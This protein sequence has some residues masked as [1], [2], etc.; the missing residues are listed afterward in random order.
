MA[1]SNVVGF[2]S[3]VSIMLVCRR[4]ESLKKA[5]QKRFEEAYKFEKPKVLG[6]ARF[7]TDEDCKRG[8]L[9]TG[10]GLRL[11]YTQSGRLLTY[12]GVSHLLAL[13]ATGLGKG[14]DLLLGAI[15]SL[16]K[17]TL[18]ANDPKGQLLVVSQKARMLV[19]PVLSLNPYGLHKEVTKGVHHVRYNPMAQLRADDPMLGIRCDKIADG[20]IWGGDERSRFWDDA[21]KELLAGI[22]MALVCHGEE[23]DRNLPTLCRVLCGDVYGYCRDV[24]A[25]T[26]NRY[27][28]DRIGPYAADGAADV[29]TIQDTVSTARVNT[30]F[31]RNEVLG[32]SLSASDFSFKS[33]RE[34]P[35]SL[36]LVLPVNS[37]D[38]CDRYYRLIFA[39]ALSEM[40][41][42][43]CLGKTKVLFL[44]DEAGSLG[45]MKLL[46]DSITIVRGFGIQ[47]WTV[48]TDVPQMKAIYGDRFRSF[49]ANCGVK[50]FFP[51]RD[52]VT[53]EEISQMSGQTEVLTQ[54]RNI[55]LGHDGEP[56]V[57]DGWS[58]HS[59]P[60]LL[61]HEATDL[62]GD[63]LLIMSDAKGM[64]RAKRR[65][66]WK[67]HPGK[68]CPDP[69]ETKKRR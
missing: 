48:F 21:A 25:L 55:G 7:S 26:K 38:V 67:T 28:Q 34:R 37:S 58:Q 13:G 44:L 62:P 64:I 19:G 17:V 15:I 59:R 6:D 63:E 11:G 23:K 27:I 50:L 68:F 46:E 3:L 61:P 42:E 54:S 20:L 36:F 52:S 60:L 33:L 32:P 2:V 41:S 66:Y 31:I 18:I 40:L 5:K 53:A 1:D 9:L 57:T 4:I 49:F 14:R 8:Q 56:T 35:C 22:M 12:A 43:D 16:G 30:A 51:A 65:P 39:S 10:K 29:R 47:L 45:R 24:V 69:Y